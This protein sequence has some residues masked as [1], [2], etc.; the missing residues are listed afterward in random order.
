MAK[1]VLNQWYSAD[2]L[3]TQLARDIF[4]MPAAA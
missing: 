3:N 4:L 2:R 1:S